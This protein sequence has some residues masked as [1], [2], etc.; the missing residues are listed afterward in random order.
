M[1][2]E[3]LTVNGGHVQSTSPPLTLLPLALGSGGH[4]GHG[5]CGIFVW[6]CP[7]AGSELQ[8]V[9]PGSEGHCSGLVVHTVEGSARPAFAIRQS[10]MCKA[11]R[12]RFG[13]RRTLRRTSRSEL[14]ARAT[15][16][17]PPTH[18]ALGSGYVSTDMITRLSAEKA[19]DPISHGPVHHRG[20]A[21]RQSSC[22]C[23]SRRIAR[24]RI[25]P[26]HGE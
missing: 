21:K 8:Y 16:T 14:E 25:Q 1:A 10:T 6:H 11:A 4:G 2:L 24:C 23:S 13:A 19:V 20:A 15:C 9:T 12:E 5:R 7:G 18:V 22:A 17:R 26:A 3:T